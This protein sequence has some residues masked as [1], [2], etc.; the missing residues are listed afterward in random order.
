MNT[1]VA[2]KPQL[3]YYLYS[4]RTYGTEESSLIGYEKILI[5]HLRSTQVIPCSLHRGRSGR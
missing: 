1:V 4:N 3:N 5:S 2:V